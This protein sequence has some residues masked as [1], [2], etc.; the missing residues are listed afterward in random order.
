MGPAD[1]SDHLLYHHKNKKSRKMSKNLIFCNFRDKDYDLKIEC[2][3]YYIDIYLKMLTT[4]SPW[5]VQVTVPSSQ[6]SKRA[7]ILCQ[8]FYVDRAGPNELARCPTVNH[9][10]PAR[11][12][13]NF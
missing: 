3:S 13:E 11:G 10:K 8:A 1:S 5:D 2:K 4:S 6:S 12:L 7:D 9:L